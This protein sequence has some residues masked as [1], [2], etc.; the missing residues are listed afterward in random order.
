V[1]SEQCEAYLGCETRTGVDGNS[2]YGCRVGTAMMHLEVGALGVQASRSKV[3][4][5]LNC[6]GVVNGRAKSLA[7]YP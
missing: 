4:V 5:Y 3:K 7:L 1:G 2:G 6:N